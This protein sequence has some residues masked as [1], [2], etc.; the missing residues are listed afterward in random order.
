M[1]RAG[2]RGS[3]AASER[4]WQRSLHASRRWAL[5]G[6][7]LGTALA[8]IAYAPATWLA[9]MVH[10][11]SG[12]RLLLAEAQGSVWSG[13]AVAVLQGGP[14]SRDAAALPGRLHWRL[15]P[16]WYGAELVLRQACCLRDEL[17]VGLRPGWQGLAVSVPAKPEGIGQWPAQW[18]GGLG[19]PWNTLQLGGTLRLSTPGFA[20]TSDRQRLHFAG[21]LDI[22]LLGATSRISPIE[23]LG[24]Y[25]LGLRGAAAEPTP[26]QAGQPAAAATADDGARIQLDTLDGAL[27]LTGSGR[28]AASGLRLRGEA[29]AEPGQ[30]AGLA[31]LLNIIGRRQGALSVISIG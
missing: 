5:W 14:D 26:G 13:S 10:R 1:I 17:R 7:V 15:R 29:R 30:E 20:L 25:R 19:T 6:A 23:P 28:W 12:Q 21:A 27:R 22:E 24:S 16:R 4:A 9:N 8:A 2:A 11:A 3:P 31:N 18:L